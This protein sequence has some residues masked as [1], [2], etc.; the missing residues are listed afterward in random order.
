MVDRDEIFTWMRA[1]GIA[2]RQSRWAP[3]LTERGVDVFDACIAPINLYLLALARRPDSRSP[4]LRA[5]AAARIDDLRTDRPWRRAYLHQKARWQSVSRTRAEVVFWPVEPTHLRQ[6]V[7]IARE[8]RR[9]GVSYRFVACRPWIFDA[10]RRLGERPIYTKALWED[11]LTAARGIGVDAAARLE[12][13]P[14]I[15]LPVG[16]GSCPPEQVVR[17]LRNVLTEMLPGVH[18]SIE[19]TEAI[20]RDLGPKVLV[21]GNDVTYE[22]RTAVLRARTRGLPTISTMHGS[23]T[24]EPLDG[25]HIADRFLLYG[26]NDRRELQ[27]RGNDS[28]RLMVCGA[29]YLDECPR[30]TGR[31]DPAI[32]KRLR[33]SDHRPYILAA[34][35]GPGH[36]TSFQHFSGL[37]ESVMRLSA[38]LPHVDVVAKLHKKDRVE[39]YRVPKARVPENRLQI[40]PYFS[41]GLPVDIF[42]W[43]QGCALVLTTASTVAVE[44]MLMNVPVITM[45]FASEYKDVDFI[46]AGATV[47]VTTEV[48]LERTVRTLLEQPDAF[49]DVRQRARS[50][51]T[52]AFGPLDARSAERCAAALCQLID[53]RHSSALAG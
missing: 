19:T 10:L 5:R 11:R 37:V 1:A 34:T 49:S 38:R 18:A 9:L 52:D 26:E 32:A 46:E 6:L 42:S 29:P 31:I 41:D 28:A 35:S 24:G 3:A 48:D 2:L 36:C 12:A 39:Y 25:A 8:L 27:R 20:V 16:P 50:F 13:A 7:P 44:S 23:V 15:L 33:L 53:R 14:G 45:D 21:V 43:L 22:G 17:V 40:V 4:T 30:Q 47:H 51:V